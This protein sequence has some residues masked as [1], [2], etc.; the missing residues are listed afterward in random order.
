VSVLRDQSTGTWENAQESLSASR[1]VDEAS[2]SGSDVAQFSD[3]ALVISAEKSQLKFSGLV[4]L[5]AIRRNQ[6]AQ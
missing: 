5:L 1:L 3:A 4:R 2:S 6:N